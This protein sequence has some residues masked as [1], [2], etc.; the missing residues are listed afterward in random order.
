MAFNFRELSLPV[1]ALLFAVLAVG[2]IIGGLYAPFSPIKTKVAELVDAQTRV[3]KLNGEVVR[4][5]DVHRRIAEFRSQMEAQQ[6]E[7]ESLR[8]IVPAEK[9]ADDFIRDV[10]AQATSSNVALR[11]MTAKQINVREGYS[12]MPFE[13]EVDG[14]YYAVLD[15]FTRLGRV[16]RIINV[17]DLAFSGLAEARGKKY[18]VRAGTTVTGTFMATTFFTS[19]AEQP[20]SKQAGKQ[21]APA[22]R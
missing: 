3:S 13:I 19:R 6:K 15:F 14:P 2:L 16:S 9:N 10:H 17:G 11:R 4:L 5:R 8:N 18:P 21:P 1:Q 12:E 20:P 22:K 7:L